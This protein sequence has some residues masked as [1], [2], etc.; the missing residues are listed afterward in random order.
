MNAGLNECPETICNEVMFNQQEHQCSNQSEVGNRH[1]EPPSTDASHTEKPI[2]E[3]EPEE[4]EES[5]VRR[6]NMM[7]KTPRA[8]E[9]YDKPTTTD[10][11]FL[12]PLFKVILRKKTEAETTPTS[13]PPAEDVLYLRAAE[14]EAGKNTSKR[15]EGPNVN[16]ELEKTEEKQ[17]PHRMEILEITQPSLLDPS[18]RDP[19]P[20]VTQHSEPSMHMEEKKEDSP[21]NLYF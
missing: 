5:E 11:D 14:K 6:I 2:S 20:T 15:M 17:S 3:G 12:E 10:E 9:R 8:D 16:Q 1:L 19:A 21:K 4:E 13:Q 7:K 18:V